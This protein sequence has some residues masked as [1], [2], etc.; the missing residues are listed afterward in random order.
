MGIH[1]VTSD[2]Q[3]MNWQQMVGKRDDVRAWWSMCA[4]SLLACVMLTSGASAQEL[5]YNRDIRP[6]LAEHC[7]ACH[8][9]DSAARKADLR[10]DQRD[11]AMTMGAIAPGKPDESEALR[12]IMSE[13]PME[14][15]PPPETKKKV[16]AE[17]RE[18]LAQWITQG[19]PYQLHWSFLAPTRPPVPDAGQWASGKY[20]SWPRNPIDNFLLARMAA[21]GLEPAEEADLRTLARRVSLDLTGLPPAP[22]LVE[23]FVTEAQGSDGE[24]SPGRS[25]RVDRAYERLV[26]TLLDSQHWGE[27][28]GRYWLDYAR[29]AD[30]HGIHF[31]NYR[32]MWSYRDWVIRAFNANMPYDQF[33]IENL[34][35]DLLPDATLDQKIGSG[36]N[37]CN[38]TT[39]EGGIIDE[40]YLVLYTRD[41]TEAVSQV[42]MGLT[43]GCAVCHSHKFDPLSQKEFYEMS[44]FF[45][46]STQGA[47]DG[48]IQDTPPII[49]VPQAADRERWNALPGLIE[50]ARANLEQ[51]RQQA[52]GDFQQWLLALTPEKLNATLPSA[53]MAFS[54]PLDEGDGRKLHATVGGEA[55]ELELAESATWRDGAVGKALQVQGAAA[56]VG[57]AGDFELSD[58]FTCSAWVNLPASDDAGAICARMEQGP[59]YRGWDFWTQRRTVGLHIISAWPDQ[60]MKV[61]GKAQIP[62]DQWVHVAVSYDGSSKSAGVKVYYNGEPQ[63]TNVEN[64]KLSGS[65]RTSVPLKIGQRNSSEPLT[66]AMQDLRIYRGVLSP[67]E[68]LALARLSKFARLVLDAQQAQASG[69]AAST[70]ESQPADWTTRIPPADRDALYRFWLEAFDGTYRSMSDQIA[71]LEREQADLKSRGTIAHVMQEKPEAPM[72]YVLFRGEY[73]KRRDQVSADT[74]DVLPPF[75]ADAPRNRLGFARWLLQPDQPLTARVTVNRFW[76]EVFGTGLVKTA[77]DFGVTGELPS[78]PELLDWLAVDFRESGWDVKRLF[79]MMVTSSAYRQSA[80]VTPAKLERDPENRLLSRGPRFRMDAEMVRDYALAASGL[81]VEKIGGPSVKPYQPPGVWEA[82]AMDVSNT[83]FYQQGNGEDLYRR[84][85][86]TFVKRMAPPASMEIFNAPNR[87]YCVVRRERTNTALQ[88]LVTMNDPQF[89]EAARRLAQTAVSASPETDERLKVIGLRLVSREFRPDERAVIHQ[90]LNALLDHYRAHPEDAA[91]LLKVGEMSAPEVMD[92]PELAGWTML[93]N[94]LMNLDEVLNK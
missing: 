25:D 2:R 9:P 83:R 55:R 50:T 42:W 4:A 53:P 62:A 78:H 27:H 46:N 36:F 69:S 35:G 58:P 86:Y 79:R 29:Y 22:E 56:E 24:G 94:E 67:S 26:D 66:G 77:G 89:I 82:I 57:D 33:T 87:E 70:S 43:A 73:D 11:A 34:A 92:K 84:S 32:E 1:R 28:R 81:L 10:L 49:V 17:Q 64:D 45:N 3:Q 31:D 41:R 74:P 8:G 63:E 48:N 75:P 39:N 20:V 90:S 37:R 76:Q 80:Q 59:Q 65:I 13:D 61:L 72:A 18:K 40:E 14:V 85:M 21:A 68:V 19:A 38:M 5:E 7:F 6:I 15:M 71:A 12:R 60:G 47:R 44:A 23:R 88:S 30:T 52:G 93:C 54:A 16:T 91:E 51:R